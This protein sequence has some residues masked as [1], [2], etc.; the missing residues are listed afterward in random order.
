[1]LRDDNNLKAD[2][3]QAITYY[4]V[5]QYSRCESPISIPTPVMY[6]HLA[7]FRAR[8]Y[9]IASET[10]SGWSFKENETEED[11]QKKEVDL[12]EKLN[13]RIKVS[14]SIKDRMFF[15]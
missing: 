11:R 13:N 3:L 14:P 9:I 5:F 2:D 15:C 12:A 4:T 8:Q 1:M 6:A 10:E 7:A